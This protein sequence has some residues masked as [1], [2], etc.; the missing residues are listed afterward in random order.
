M[1]DIDILANDTDIPTDGILTVSEPSNGI[2]S[3]NDGGTPNDPSDDIVTYIPD[4]DFNGTDTFTYTVCDTATPVNCSTAT[5][6]ITVTPIVD[7]VD[8]TATTNSGDSIDIDIIAN[9]NDVPSDGVLTID[10]FP[11]HGDATID[12]GGTPNDPSDDIVKYTPAD[13]FVGADTFTYTICDN[14]V[15]ANCSTATV[16]IIVDDVCLTVYNEFSPNG[17]GINDYLK[18]NCIQNFP[19]N[20]IEVF[21]RWGNTVY[22]INGY[23][24]NDPSKRFDGISN[25]RITIQTNDELAVGTYFYILNLGDGSPIRKGWIYINR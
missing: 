1:V 19:N 9:D 22:T 3:I 21:N 10:D 4:M 24:N 14:S 8:D 7:A 25:G 18:I 23:N 15:P 6:T 11:N 5:V 2:V 20:T 13:D 17:D 16:V 12:D